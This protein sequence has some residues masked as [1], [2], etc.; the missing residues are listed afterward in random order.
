[1]KKI[2]KTA[3]FAVA[4]VAAGIGGYKAYIYSE[5]NKSTLVSADIDA[6]AGIWNDI[7]ESL[8]SKVHKCE[9]EP[10]EMTINLGVVSWTLHGKEEKCRDGNSVDFCWRCAMCDA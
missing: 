5:N 1:M 10:C 4:V 3:I 6:Q 8:M 9:E 2:I 7:V